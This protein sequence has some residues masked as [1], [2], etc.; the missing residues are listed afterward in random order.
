LLTATTLG[1]R[2]N[3]DNGAKANGDTFAS[4]LSADGPSSA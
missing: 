4:S 1:R 3:G 2:A